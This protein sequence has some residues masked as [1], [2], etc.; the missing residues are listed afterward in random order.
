LI[1]LGV[2]LENMRTSGENEVFP[3]NLEADVQSEVS[4]QTYGPEPGHMVQSVI[5]N[6]IFTNRLIAHVSLF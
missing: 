5:R 1:V 6:F 3:E 4:Q 2:D